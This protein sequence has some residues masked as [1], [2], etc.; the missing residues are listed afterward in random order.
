MTDLAQSATTARRHPKLRLAAIAATL[1][2]LLAVTVE[3]PAAGATAPTTAKSRV[4]S[5]QRVNF[6]KRTRKHQAPAVTK[7]TPSAP[8]QPTTPAKPATP[9]TPTSPAKPATPTTPAKPTTPTSPTS[10][11]TPTTPT[12]PTT[13]TTPIVPTVDSIFT[14]A[15]IR[16]FSLLQAAP[17]AITEVADPLGSGQTVLK[18]TV[19]DKDVAP[20]TPTE[21]PRAQALSPDVIHSGDEIWLSTKFMLPADF[22]ASVPGWMSL[23]SIYGEPFGGSSPWQIGL[24]G[25]KMSW[26]RNRTYGFDTPW[27]VP[28]IRGRWVTV[29]LHERFASDGWVEMWIDGNPVNLFASGSSYNPKKVAATEHLSMQTMDSSNNGASGNAAKIMSYREVGMFSSTTVYFGALRVG[30]T[31]ASVGG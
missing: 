22:P 19:S 9:T 24:E 5:A 29:L 30:K 15:K 6:R 16:D 20:I 27:E 13:P 21:N 14:G 31:R 23:V 7:P 26:M 12:S 1:T 2:C 28:M 3:A 10:P 8:T 18:M 11:T 25:N 17:N 4:S